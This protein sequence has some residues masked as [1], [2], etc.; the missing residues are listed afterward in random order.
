MSRMPPPTTATGVTNGPPTESFAPSN[1]HLFIANLR[2]LDLEKLPDWPGIAVQTFSTR[3][4][5][6]NQ[7][8][9]IRCVEWALFRLFEL[10]DPAEAREKLQPFF[11]PLEPLQS[12]N[13]RTALYRA[14]NELKKNGNLGRE[15]TLR[16]TMLDDCAGTKLLEVLAVFSTNVVKAR[17]VNDKHGETVSISRRIS[18]AHALDDRSQQSMLP[19]AIAHKAS[20]TALLKQKARLTQRYGCLSEK[21]NELSQDLGAREASR[22]RLRTTDHVTGIDVVPGQV[23]ENWVGNTRC[24]DD[25]IYGADLPGDH[26]LA[27]GF[28]DIWNATSNGLSLE[29]RAIGGELQAR[30]DNRVQH[31]K[32]RVAHWQGFQEKLRQSTSHPREDAAP[33]SE[34]RLIFDA[35]KGIKI[36]SQSNEASTSLDHIEDGLH[37]AHTSQATYDQL[38]ASMKEQLLSGSS[39]NGRASPTES[40][41]MSRRHSTV[42]RI[43]SLDTGAG[44]MDPRRQTGARR[45]LLDAMT[46]VK[47]QSSRSVVPVKS[48]SPAIELTSLP[49]SSEA[50]ELDAMSQPHS[51]DASGSP[52]SAHHEGVDATEQLTAN[53]R[54]LSL[55]DRTRLSM[56]PRI[57]REEP[58]TNGN[59]AASPVEP[60][61]LLPE[62]AAQAGALDRR[63]SLLDR[64]RKSMLFLPPGEATQ[65]HKPRKSITGR[66]GKRTSM[67]PINQF[68]TP[69]RKPS[70]ALAEMSGELGSGQSTPRDALFSDDAEYNSV[71]KS[72]PKIALSPVVTPQVEASPHDVLGALD[73]ETSFNS[74]PLVRK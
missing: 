26:I 59:G 46:E 18:L 53:L 30:L 25:L 32:R 7:K 51:I 2:L 70:Y 64:T 35:H 6:Q 67:F 57:H 4:A 61:P 37:Q 33:V 1:T 14:L 40:V 11:P 55:A 63:A 71:F 36:G 49:Q 16:K 39:A 9:R 45:S 12:L 3:D 60:E 50:P 52:R 29:H 74:S 21:L 54:H 20:L 28:D 41:T 44:S 10:W 17:M 15:T 43:S 38:I 23:R 42:A 24:A 27:R 34:K 5:S 69:R 65:T 31:Q 68:E 73:G 13:L 66:P 58:I 19:L 72:R 22:K 47:R 62:P 48:P 8:H 56:A